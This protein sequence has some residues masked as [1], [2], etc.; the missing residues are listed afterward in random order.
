MRLSQYPKNNINE[1]TLSNGISGSLIYHGEDYNLQ[2]KDRQ[3]EVVERI[4]DY[5]AILLAE[6]T[7]S[8]TYTICRT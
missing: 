7:Q 4:L 1:P 5:D 6:S 2:R 3:V 8:S